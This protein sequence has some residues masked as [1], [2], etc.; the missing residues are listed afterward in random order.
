[1]LVGESMKPQTL[2]GRQAPNTL[3][4]FRDPSTLRQAQGSG[5]AFLPEE[6]VL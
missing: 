6:A 2:K 4:G 1:M 3:K 5:Q